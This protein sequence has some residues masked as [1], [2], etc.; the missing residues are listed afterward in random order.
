MS[1][2]DE[3]SAGSSR[4]RRIISL[5]VTVAILGGLGFGIYTY[6]FAGK[7]TAKPTSTV[8][9]V[10]ATM[11]QLV[12]SFATS[13]TAKAS[14]TTQLTF[15]S[16][17]YIKSVY[18]SVGQTVTA[19]QQLAQQDD[20][21]SKRALD[22]ASASLISAQIK[23]QQLVAPPLDSDVASAAQ[24][25]VNAQSQVASA[26]LALQKLLTPLPTDVTAAA[27]A[28]S[29]AKSQLL[30]AQ[31]NLANASLPPTPDVLG[32]QQAA[33][34]SAQNA[35]QAATNTLN[36]AT[37]SFLGAERTYCNTPFILSQLYPCV[38]GTS[39]LIGPMPIPADAV[40]GMVNYLGVLSQTASAN[41]AI[42]TNTNAFISANSSFI[43]ATNGIE[44]ANQSLAVAQAKLTQLT[45]GPTATQ[46]APLQ[47]A[48]DSAQAGL[49]S[50]I[51]KQQLLLNPDPL[52][53]AQAQYAVTSAQAGL[54]SAQ[55]KQAQLLA[56]PTSQNIQLQ[57]Q[58]INQAQIAYQGQLDSY[59]MLLLKAPFAGVI[60]NITMNAGDTSGAEYIVLTNPDAMRID[61]QVSETDV[62]G[63]KAGQFGLATFDAVPGQTFL[64]KVAGVSTT[65]TVTQGVVTYPVQTVI[66][67]GPNA[68]PAED[69]QALL[70][71]FQALSA[72]ARGSSASSTGASG[73]NFGP[74]SGT[75]GFG[76]GPGG[77]GNSAP[78]QVPTPSGTAQP[79]RGGGGQGGANGTPGAGRTPGANGTAGAGQLGAAALQALLNAPL[80]ITGMSANVSLLES[81]KTN[82][83]LVPT[84][85][86]KR[87]G[88]TTFVL[89]PDAAGK[90]TQQTVGLGG[91]DSTN[92]EIVSG[93]NDGDVV[94]IGATLTTGTPVASSTRPPTPAGGVR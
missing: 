40:T 16:S 74:G 81:V 70:T 46:L 25:V 57:Q 93:L 78:L 87:Q 60:G 48:V 13:G 4:L 63:L 84:T 58:S 36:S 12:S 7:T 44:T 9:Q 15:Q 5:V 31:Q 47:A 65:P 3:I 53:V 55:A 35:V 28:I 6:F 68:V 14:L 64:V 77:P 8:Q 29:S 45:S 24:A 66:L 52:T 71:A 90:P 67:H 85:A 21:Q 18:V 54:I 42:T 39:A 23:L 79:G 17:G 20:V 82:V 92:T 72:G 91:S 88:R 86:I 30:T 2:A 69:Q 59:N 89:I 41:T 50:A 61:L 62:T 76:G 94:L 83:L 33:V 75:G 19:G 11:G 32:A 38:P 26:Q 80:P 56:G 34:S 27:Q 37:A 1:D 49:D 10:K 51:A 73:S 22:N 43:S